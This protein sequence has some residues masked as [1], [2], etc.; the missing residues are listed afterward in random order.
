LGFQF[1]DE[2]V[3]GVLTSG[4]I[5][6]DDVVNKEENGEPAVCEEARLLLALF[7]AKVFES[8]GQVLLP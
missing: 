7:E 1:D 4:T 2:F 3:S 5:Q 6:L 8:C